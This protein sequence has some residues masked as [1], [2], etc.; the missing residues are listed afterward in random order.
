MKKPRFTYAGR[1]E[2]FLAYLLDTIILVAP[3][4]LIL[5]AFGSESGVGLL[6]AF[7]I[8]AVYATWFVGS[9]WQATPGQRLLTLHIVRTDGR[10]L[11]YTA[12]FERYLA[13]LLPSLPLYSSFLPP[14]FARTLAGLL[15]MGWFAP[16]LFTAER[17]GIHDMLCGTRVVTGRADAK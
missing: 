14:D 16:I 12:A 17:T 10:K 7:A 3:K 6:L 5:G 9:H 15:I 11:N 4:Y 2:R 1:L 8:D 13:Y